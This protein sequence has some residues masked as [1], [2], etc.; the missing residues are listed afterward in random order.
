M[1]REAAFSALGELVFHARVLD[2]FAGSGAY[3]IE[4][5]RGRGSGVCG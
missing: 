1:V 4:E 3:G 2:L 5:P